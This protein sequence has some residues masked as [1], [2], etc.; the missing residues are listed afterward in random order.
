MRRQILTLVVAALAVT[1]TAVAV[2]VARQVGDD[3]GPSPSR[4]A[5]D[6]PCPELEQGPPVPLVERGT[7]ELRR[8]GGA[9]QPTTAVFAADGSGDGFLGERAGRVLRVESGRITDDVVLDLTDDTM[10]EG[11][12]GLLALAYG[13]DGDWLY[14]YRA[15]ADRN[16]VLV[17]YPLDGD[18]RPDPGAGR[19]ILAV[20]HPDSVQHHG[21]SLAVGP[22]GLL[23]VGF[24]D[25]GGLGD[26]R[27]NAQDPRTLLGKVLRIDPTPAA[28]EPYRIPADNPFVDDERRAPEIWLLGVRNPYRLGLDAETGELWLGDVGQ[29]CWEE[30]NR[31]PTG[32]DG[33]GGS[34]LGWDHVEGTYPFED[35]AVPGRE[36]EP[37][38]QHAHGDGW[39]GIVA[40]YVPRASSVPSLD[41]RLLYTD[42]C[43]GQVLA[44]AV[45]GLPSG[46]VRLLD[47][48]LEATNP[49]AIVPG[50]AGRPWVLSLDGR[51][52]EIVERSR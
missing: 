44:L 29:S 3:D 32:A 11:D 10:H 23:Y 1:G 7:L 2:T 24:G 48:R 26:P 40:G 21:G 15:D 12:G 27:D 8:V 39:C 5:T 36:L 45:D 37:F 35:G 51:V 4:V 6:R 31:L 33:A 22:D 14:V 19:E 17:A 34:N 43:A 42:Y 41:G 20:D 16:D 46:T 38:Q 28:A 18:G 30:L 47:T 13:P 25:G 49:T 52:S 50:P 9:E